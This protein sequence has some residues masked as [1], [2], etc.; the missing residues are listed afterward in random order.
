MADYTCRCVPANTSTVSRALASANS[1]VNGLAERVTDLETTSEDHETRITTLESVNE[2]PWVVVDSEADLEDALATGRKILLRGEGSGGEIQVSKMLTVG[3]PGTC[4]YGYGYKPG[5]TTS[6]G[7]IKA[8]WATALPAYG[9]SFAPV[10]FN[11]TADKVEFGG[12]EFEGRDDADIN[13]TT[14]KSFIL[15]SLFAGSDVEDVY[16]HDVR[17]RNIERFISKWGYEGA[18]VTRRLRAE[19]NYVE[20][21]VNFTVSI[22][23]SLYQSVFRDNVFIQRADAAAATHTWSQGFYVTSDVLDTIIDNNVVRNAN[24]MGIE[25]MSGSY[26][27][28]LFRPMFRNK[29]TNNRVI[30][31]GSFGIS[32]AYARD[33]LIS[34]N[35]VD[36]A[37]GIG[38]ESTNGSQGENSERHCAHILGNSIRNVT[39]ATYASGISCDRGTGDIVAHNRVEDVYSDFSGT[40]QHAY[41]RGLMIYDALRV[42]ARGNS[43]ER[44]DGCGVLLQRNAETAADMQTIIEGNT[45]RVEETDTKALYAVLLQGAIAVVRNNVAWEPTSLLAQAKFACQ[46]NSANPIYAGQSYTA[47][48]IADGAFLDSNLV[49]SY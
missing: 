44:V 4:I 33:G 8:S 19:R 18:G 13:D 38:I 15:F 16:I 48:I 2:S 40:S 37:T 41:A 12:F 42:Q 21:V 28:G 43:F 14:Y 27:A 7:R 25:M 1:A 3:V 11:I 24:R 17:A 31:A 22:Q 29:I 45:F 5:S 46:F 10:I 36:G 9:D 20:N 47:P 34:G 6:Y 39:S 32:M 23:E 49:I 35:T 30:D 26:T